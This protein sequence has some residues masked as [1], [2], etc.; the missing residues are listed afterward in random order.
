VA[1]FSN[2]KISLIFINIKVV[3]LQYNAIAFIL[4]SPLRFESHWRDDINGINNKKIDPLPRF[5]DILSTL[6]F[7]QRQPPPHPRDKH[8]FVAERMLI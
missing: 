3:F 7:V 8:K 6:Y 4:N 1:F 5:Q 2:R